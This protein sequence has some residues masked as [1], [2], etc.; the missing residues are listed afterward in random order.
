MG[1]IVGVGCV[2]QRADG[3]VEVFAGD[4]TGVFAE[5]KLKVE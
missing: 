3:A 1:G 4:G 5:T 2:A